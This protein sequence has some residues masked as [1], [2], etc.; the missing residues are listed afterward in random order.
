[1]AVAV[2]V[3]EVAEAAASEAVAIEVAEAAASEA[4]AIEVAEAA[5]SEGAGVE[6][7]NRKFRVKSRSDI[8]FHGMEII[9][10]FCTFGRKQL[11]CL[12]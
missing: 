1:L 11:Y 3:I 12:L 9:Y 2:E 5:A 7:V 6:V 4:V 10:K 8:G